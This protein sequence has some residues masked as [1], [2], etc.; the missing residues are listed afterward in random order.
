M[1]A[2]I[3]I[4]LIL[5]LWLVTGAVTWGIVREQVTSLRRDMDAMRADVATYVTRSEYESRHKD[6]KGSVDRIE[7]KVDQ[8]IMRKIAG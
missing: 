2:W 5:L 3:N 8:L 1:S 7:T 4:A 6:L